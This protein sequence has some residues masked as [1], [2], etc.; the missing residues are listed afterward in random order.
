MVLGDK[1]LSSEGGDLTVGFL[2]DAADLVLGD[3]LEA[4]SDDQVVDLLRADAVDV[5]LLDH[6]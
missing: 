1:P 3:A 2:A 5:D 4:R 6:R